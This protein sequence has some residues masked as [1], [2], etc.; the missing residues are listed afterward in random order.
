ME[1]STQP[2]SHEID[3]LPCQ[4]PDNRILTKLIYAIGIGA[5]ILD[6]GKASIL[7]LGLARPLNH[8]CPG[9]ASTA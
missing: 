8:I 9:A 7:S 2:A 3:S 1:T 4:F 6:L 5:T